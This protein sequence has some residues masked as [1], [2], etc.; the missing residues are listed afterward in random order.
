[1]LMDLGGSIALLAAWATPTAWCTAGYLGEDL[2]R[3]A[4]KCFLF[5]RR[6]IEPFVE[7]AMCGNLMS[8]LD[9]L[10]NNLRICLSIIARHEKRSLNIMPCEYVQHS[11]DSALR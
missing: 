3:L 4:Q 10:L 9:D 7:I 2:M 8:L 11:Q 1:I 5:I 6:D